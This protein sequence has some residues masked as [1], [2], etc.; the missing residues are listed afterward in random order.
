MVERTGHSGEHYIAHDRKEYWHMW[1]AAIGGGSADRAY[2][3]HQ[4]AR[5]RRPLA[6]VRRRLCRWDQLRRQFHYACRS[7]DW[8][9]PPSNRPRRRPRLQESSARTAASNAKTSSPN[10]FRASPAPN[11]PRHSATSS[12][13]ASG[14]FS[15][16][17]FGDA[18]S[19]SPI[20]L[21]SRPRTFT[22]R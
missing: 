6:A 16:K 22:K 21:P 18:C 10:S 17:P 15:S 1:A 7:S 12:P 4:A 13:S 19:R 11:S 2:R 3:G 8:F 5:L 9:S 14:P 20:F